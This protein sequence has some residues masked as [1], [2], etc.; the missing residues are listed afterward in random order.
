MRLACFWS[1]I[2]LMG[3]GVSPFMMAMTAG[4]PGLLPAAVLMTS[5]V[6]AGAS[7]Y[8]YARPSDS[9]LYMKGPLMG[10]LMATIGL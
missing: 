1:A 10:A 8:A 9:L 6:C 5:G 2:G 4:Q 7:L 3:V